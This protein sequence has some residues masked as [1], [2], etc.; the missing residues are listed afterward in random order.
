MHTLLPLILLSAVAA[1]PQFDVQLL[2]GSKVS[3]G[4]AAWTETQM[5]VETAARPP[6]VERGQGGLH[7]GA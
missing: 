2:D 3:G 7:R 4:L 5:V 1:P 6:R